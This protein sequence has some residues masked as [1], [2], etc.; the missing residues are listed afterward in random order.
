MGPLG[1]VEQLPRQF[2]SPLIHYCLTSPW[3]AKACWLRAFR[4]DGLGSPARPNVPHDGV[5]AMAAR[6]PITHTPPP[7]PQHP[8]TLS[9]PPPCTAPCSL[10]CRPSHSGQR[11][12]PLV[13]LERKISEVLF[14]YI[15]QHFFVFQTILALNVEV[16][17]ARYL[18][19]NTDLCSSA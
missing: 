19:R 3:Q 18:I 15:S 4:T 16:L 1:P 14:T 6:G 17:H 12:P 13:Y 9:P 5:S 10:S 7:T 2:P 8:E 11:N